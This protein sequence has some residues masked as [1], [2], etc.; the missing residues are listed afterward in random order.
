MTFTNE[1][2][3]S[4]IGMTHDDEDRIMA[5]L[6][7][8]IRDWIRYDAAMDWGVEQVFDDWRRGIPVADIL[9]ELHLI[10]RQETRE[11]YGRSHPQASYR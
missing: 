8:A 2:K 4:F 5:A 6:P 9:R 10:Q 3:A 11:A 7:P 1:S